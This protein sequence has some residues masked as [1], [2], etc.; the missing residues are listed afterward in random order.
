MAGRNSR[1]KTDASVDTGDTASERSILDSGESIIGEP[2]GIIESSGESKPATGYVDPTT[3]DG[4]DTGNISG[5]SG[6]TSK[7][8]RGR[9]R[10][11]TNKSTGRKQASKT[12]ISLG[13]ILYSVHLMG[14]IMLKI[15]ELSMTAEESSELAEAI[16]T[17]T[18]LY[19]VPLMDEK[20]MAWINLAMVGAKVYAPR[21]VAITVNKKKQVPQ[22]KLQMVPKTTQQP[23]V[24]F[25]ANGVM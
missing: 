6:G 24:D 23:L 1:G 15:P 17:V 16:N 4:S 25:A 13:N 8:R 2:D 10:G 14:S 22:Q 11:S 9:P 7:P 19:D 12:S 21:V 20:T 3:L 18:E 5:E